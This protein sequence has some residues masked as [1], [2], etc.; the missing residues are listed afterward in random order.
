MPAADTRDLTD[1]EIHELDDLLAAVPEP[2][3]ALEGDLRRRFAV[4]CPV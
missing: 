3:E 1:A 2:F 4:P